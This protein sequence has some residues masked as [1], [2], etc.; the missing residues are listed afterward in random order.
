MLEIIYGPV[1][2]IYDLERYR[3]FVKEYRYEIVSWYDDQ[4]NRTGQYGLLVYVT[5]EGAD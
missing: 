5:S 2:G 4:G 1:E 3:R